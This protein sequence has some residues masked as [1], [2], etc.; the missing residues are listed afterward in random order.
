M[1]PLVLDVAYWVGGEQN[2]VYSVCR[3]LAEWVG[4]QSA[5]WSPWKGVG[6]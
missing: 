5:V 3:E 6:G 4:D 1:H 2:T